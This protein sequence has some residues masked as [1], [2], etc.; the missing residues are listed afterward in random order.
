MKW[1]A[2][3]RSLIQAS[4]CVAVSLTAP[5]SFGAAP[6]QQQAQAQLLD[7]AELPCA[8][9]FFGVSDYYY[10]FAADSKVLIAHQRT[11][12]LNWRDE[13]KNYLAKVHRGWTAWTPPDQ[14]VP[15][16]YDD[17]HIWVTGPSGKQIR[18][19]QN[20]SVDIFTDSRCRSAVKAK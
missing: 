18:L 12:V 1:Y 10:C 16:S 6:G 4:V 19:T 2:S 5:A 13:S 20:Y 15:I 3:A 8:N 17:K 9:C 7:H 14:T 11:R